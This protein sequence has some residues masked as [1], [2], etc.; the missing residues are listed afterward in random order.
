MKSIVRILL[1]VIIAGGV[2]SCE[3][4]KNLFD[5]DVDTVIEGDLFIEVDEIQQ[6]KAAPV[7]GFDESVTVQVLNDDLYEYE[8]EIQ[9]FKV[10]GVTVEVTSVSSDTLKLL[11]GT[12]FSVSNANHTVTWT[13]TNDWPIMEG[14]TLDLN[15]AGV[16]DEVEAILDEL[17]PFTLTAVGTCN[18]AGAVIGLRLG[19]ETTVTVNPS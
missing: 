16:F 8:N 4:I 18:E 1:L 10:S 3:K 14:T 17:L 2:S 13:V 9:D 12:Y 6:L 7:Y 15:D 19:I 5:I 11:A